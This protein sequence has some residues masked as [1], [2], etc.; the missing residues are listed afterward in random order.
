M[1]VGQI[2]NRLAEDLNDAAPGREFTAWK[3][4]QLR[5]YLEEGFRLVSQYRPGALTTKVVLEL[6]PGSEQDLCDCLTLSADG[7]LGQSDADGV[8]AHALRPRVS[9]LEGL[10]PGRSCRSA[11]KPFRLTEFAVSREARALWVEPPVPE[12][13]KV[14]L[15]VR[16][17]VLPDVFDDDLEISSEATLP[18]IQWA[19]YRAKGVDGVSN[20]AM[21]E[22]SNQHQGTCYALLGAGGGS[23]AS[24]RV[25]ANAND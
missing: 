2:L 15:A 3:K 14:Y 16:C 23:R 6:S 10:W 5:G 18:A 20:P 25:T 19:L 13:E 17:P 24:K 21:L 4:D 11:R 8:V 22:A 7:V 12:G 1:N 9:A